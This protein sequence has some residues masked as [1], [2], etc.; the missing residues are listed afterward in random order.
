MPEQP[1][2]D[3]AADRPEPATDPHHDQPDQDA[4]SSADVAVPFEPH[5][6]DDT[7]LGDSDQHSDA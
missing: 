3:T 4:D 7:P 5:E 2:P 1:D 6:D